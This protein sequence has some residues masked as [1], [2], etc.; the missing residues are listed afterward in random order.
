MSEDKTADTLRL[1]SFE[2]KVLAQL[3]AVS[4]RLDLLEQRSKER[5]NETASNLE[6]LLKDF[7]EMNVTFNT[8]FKNFDRK[9]DV[10]NSELLQLKVD[11]R[12]IESR[13]DKLEVE[14]RPQVIVQDR[15]F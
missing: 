1:S 15:Q 9:L 10:M 8:Y 13:V 6:R 12:A 4:A 2:E 7:H 3:D 5:D 11:Q 14:V